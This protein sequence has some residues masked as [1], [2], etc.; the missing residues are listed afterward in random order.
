[1][2]KMKIGIYTNTYLT[3][4]MTFIYR[5]LK[6]LKRFDPIMMAENLDNLDIFPFEKIYSP[7][8]GKKKEIYSILYSK[9]YSKIYRIIKKTYMYINKKDIDYFC[10]IIRK[11]K[12][13]LIH[14]HFGPN[15]IKML[16]VKQKFNI[17][18]ITTFHGYDA[19]KLL[20]NK[21]YLRDLKILFKH[22]DYFIAVSKSMREKLISLGCPEI[23]II[24]HYIGVPLEQFPFKQWT[25]PL[26]G[27]AFKFIQVSNFVEKKGHI[28]TIKAFKEVHSEFPETI[29][30]F[31]G[32][33]PLKKQTEKLT[34]DLNL[35]D[36]VH[37]LGRKNEIEVSKLMHRTHAFVHHSVTSKEGDQEGIP[38]V[39]ME[40]MAVGL[41]II[42]TNH[43]GIPEL[44]KY[45][46]NGFLIEE[47]DI[48]GMA[49]AMRKLLTNYDLAKNLSREGYNI[50][51]QDFNMKKQNRKLEQIYNYILKKEEI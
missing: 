18:L 33:G 11:N 21:K 40:A 9:L 4:S 36:S 26:S 35:L 39:I 14:S 22:G 49:S 43:S 37:F 34:H 44:V 32:D 24:T 20:H 30:I 25:P 47:K 19:S 12:L 45:N 2:N 10:K 17:P 28:Y 15:G 48:G 50:V 13:A 5:Q 51:R 3:I 27:D 16:P 38:T 6:Y 23:K 8:K 46:K 41:P 31:I 29:L 1:M 7:N 42:T